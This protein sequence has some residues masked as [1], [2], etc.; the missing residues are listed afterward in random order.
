MFPILLI[1]KDIS[2]TEEYLNQFIKANKFLSYNVFRYRPEPNVIKIDQIREIKAMLTRE[3]AEKKLIIIYSFNTAKAETQN[4][5]LK[6]L[7][8]EANKAQFIIVVEDETQALPTIT[9]RC[10]VVKLVSD[11]P[12]SSFNE[13]GAEQFSQPLPQLLSNYS[14][15][16]KERAIKICDQFLGYFRGRDAINRV[17][18]INILKE[19]LVVRN[20]VLKNNLNPQMAIDHLLIFIYNCYNRYN[21]YKNYEKSRIHS[22]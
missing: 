16:N 20:L 12:T 21:G 3:K 1:S 6:T 9:S 22:Y 4:A 2:V 19:I 17:S 10:K 8:E 15:I 11:L 14:N 18:T 5:F 13:V 7:E